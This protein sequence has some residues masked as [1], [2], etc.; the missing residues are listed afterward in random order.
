MI[1]L[2]LLQTV[3]NIFLVIFS[4]PMQYLTPDYHGKVH[5]ESIAAWRGGG[6]LRTCR[7]NVRP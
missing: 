2:C 7:N 4:K 3:S 5:I 6:S 1:E